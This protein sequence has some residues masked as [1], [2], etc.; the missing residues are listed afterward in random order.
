VASVKHALET[1]VNQTIAA[2]T[3]VVVSV[4]TVQRAIHVP[5][6]NAVKIVS[7]MVVLNVKEMSAKNLNAVMI[8]TAYKNMAWTSP[9]AT[10]LLMNV[11]AALTLL[12]CV[13]EDSIFNFKFSWTTFKML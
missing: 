7:V 11:L 8:M 5:V 4:S 2:M 3:L 9:Y 10:L 1:S 12:K 6:M 13:A